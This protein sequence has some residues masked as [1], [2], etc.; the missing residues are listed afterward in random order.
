MWFQPLTHLSGFFLNISR[1]L[2]F[3]TVSVSKAET[4]SALPAGRQALTHLSGVLA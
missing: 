1:I 3:K 2:Q 4:V